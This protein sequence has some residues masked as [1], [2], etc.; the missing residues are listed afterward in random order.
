[1]KYDSSHSPVTVDWHL[2]TSAERGFSASLCK[3]EKRHY[4]SFPLRQITRIKVYLL[5]SWVEVG[6]RE[7]NKQNA[8]LLGGRHSA[9]GAPYKTAHSLS[10][11]FFL[12]DSCVFLTQMTPRNREQRFGFLFETYFL[13][14]PRHTHIFSL[15]VFHLSFLYDLLL[16]RFCE[17][18][19]VLDGARGGAGVWKQVSRALPGN[20]FIFPDPS[21]SLLRAGVSPLLSPGPHGAL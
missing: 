10:I 9:P 14:L 7:G 20:V 19:C 2:Y 16:V 5:S 6:W 17:F 21:S 3:K 4:L 15:P 18:M 11:F 12:A 1:M 13:Q 8:L